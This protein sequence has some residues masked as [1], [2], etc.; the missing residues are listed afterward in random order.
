M[1]T[2]VSMSTLFLRSLALRFRVVEEVGM[3]VARDV[4]RD[5]NGRGVYRG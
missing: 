3:V 4:A 1:T 2:A 5:G